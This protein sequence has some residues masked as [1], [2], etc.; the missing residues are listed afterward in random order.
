MITV[1]MWLF[2][3]MI[4]LLIAASVYIG[5]LLDKAKSGKE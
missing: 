1:P 3:S 5:V 2:V 4:V